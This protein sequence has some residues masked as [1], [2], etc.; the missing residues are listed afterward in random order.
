[1]C[2]SSGETTVFMWH[3]V[4]V[5]LCGW[6]SGMQN[7]VQFHFTS[8][9]P[10]YQIR[11]F[12]GEMWKININFMTPFTYCNEIC[13]AHLSVYKS[14]HQYRRDFCEKSK[15]NLKIFNIPRIIP[16]IFRNIAG[17]LFRLTAFPFFLV[18]IFVG[19]GSSRYEII[20]GVPPWK[21]PKETVA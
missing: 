19:R 20:L 3:L 5:I 18:K 16:H 11:A 14:V 8:L 2:P 1:M 12:N 17:I 13:I 15:N 4:L 21:K 10:A 6:L 9:H 7:E